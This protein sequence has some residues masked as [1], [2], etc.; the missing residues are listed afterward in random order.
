VEKFIKKNSKKEIH[1]YAV[2]I[3]EYDIDL[4]AAMEHHNHQ[5]LTYRKMAEI[6]YESGQKGIEKYKQRLAEGKF[7]IL[8]FTVHSLKAN[9]LSMGAIELH[10]IA[11]SIEERESDYVYMEAASNILLVEWKRMLDGLKWFIEHT[12]HLAVTNEKEEAGQTDLGE[13]LTQLKRSLFEY[14]YKTSDMFVKQLL[15]NEEITDHALK[16]S[17]S[18]LET[19]ISE[20]DFDRA[21]ELAEDI[22]RKYG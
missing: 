19:Y 18:Q 17:L 1:K 5:L 7:D 15:Q 8:W 6:N 13:T 9:A 22:Y 2:P 20:L 11:K 21:E 3:K 16:T 4:E 12:E 14:N 10:K